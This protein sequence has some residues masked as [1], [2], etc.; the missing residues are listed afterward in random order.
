MNDM[1]ARTAMGR[2]FV[3]RILGNTCIESDSLLL[4]ARIITVI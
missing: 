2:K 4:C 1:N 3:D